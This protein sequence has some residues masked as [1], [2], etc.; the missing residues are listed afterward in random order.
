[1]AQNHQNIQKI[2]QLVLF[3]FKFQIKIDLNNLKILFK[4]T[5]SLNPLLVVTLKGQHPCIGI[6][7]EKFCKKGSFLWFFG[8]FLSVDFLK[9]CPLFA[10][11]HQFLIIYAFFSYQTPF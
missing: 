7:L 5:G 2:G 1:M 8:P 3:R 9:D 10:I 6:V 11:V 4:R